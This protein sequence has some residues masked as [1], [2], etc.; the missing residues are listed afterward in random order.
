MTRFAFVLPALALMLVNAT[1]WAQACLIESTDQQVPIRLCQQ[2]MTIPKQLFSNNFCH[3]NIPD[4]TFAISMIDECPEGAYGSC[5]GAH[6]EGV[7]YQQ[8]IHYYSDADDAP[9]LKAYCEK[10]SNGVWQSAPAAR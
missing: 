4:R 9:V 10:V 1:A 5:T 7:G 2:N 8:T 6:T 3:P